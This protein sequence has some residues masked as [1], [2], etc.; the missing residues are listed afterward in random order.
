MN[1]HEYQ[2]K[3]LLARYGVPLARGG[4]AFTAEEAEK[5]AAGIGG[6]GWAVKA[7]ILDLLVPEQR[8]VVDAH[9]RIER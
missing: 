8:I 7:Q 2:A 4:V 6:T 3:Q 1:I 9:L 5:V